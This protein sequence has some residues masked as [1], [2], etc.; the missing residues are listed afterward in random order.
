MYEVTETESG[1]ELLIEDVNSEALFSETVVGLS[2]VLSQAV[3]GTPVTHE[4]AVSGEDLE[5]LLQHWV[6]E[7][8][9]LAAEDGFVPERVFKERLGRTGFRAR[10]AGER[11]IPQERIR[12]LRRPQVTLERL[13]DGAWA[14]RIVLEDG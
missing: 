8:V 10:L 9:R 12:P 13:E 11:G 6:E 2:G 4:V 14:A 7:L 1:A 3:G 5:G